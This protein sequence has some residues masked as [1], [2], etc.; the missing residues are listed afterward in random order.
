MVL[1]QIRR[2]RRETGKSKPSEE[3][4]TF[5]PAYREILVAAKEAGGEEVLDDIEEWI[6]DYIEEEEELPEP[7]MMRTHI[8][9]MLKT[10]DLEIPEESPLEEQ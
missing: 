5:R 2:T 3:F 9:E 8:R 4:R 1:Q 7:H 10:R 6:T